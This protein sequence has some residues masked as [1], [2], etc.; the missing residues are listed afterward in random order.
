MV[1]SFSEGT[2]SPECAVTSQCKAEALEDSG[3]C[4]VFYS[5]VDRVRRRK[6]QTLRKSNGSPQDPA[7]SERR[8]SGFFCLMPKDGK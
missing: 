7:Y 4:S 5:Q 6:Q 2:L 8:I 1:C 3:M